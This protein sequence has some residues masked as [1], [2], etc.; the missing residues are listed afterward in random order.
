MQELTAKPRNELGK[1]VNALRRAG[2]LPAVV[3]GEGVK[4]EPLSV[5]LRDF[6]KVYREA[7]ES[8]VIGLKVEG[9]KNKNLNVM[10]HDVAYDALTSK[11]IHADF[12]SVRMDKELEAKVE[13]IFVGESPAVKGE[14][15]ILVKV[16]HEIEVKALPKDLP[17]EIEVDVSFLEAIGSR[18][19]VKDLT[20]PKGVKSIAEG[21]EVVALVEPPRAEEVVVE[22]A[23]TEI[24]EV[25]TEREE[26][27]EVK[28]V[29]E[30]ETKVVETT[31]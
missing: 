6:E 17:H 7:G 2:F 18:I 13:L 8:S 3:Y 27:A 19:Y 10:I 24:A 12:Y 5:S 15:G 26:K 4:S 30:A 11:P 23:T 31:K 9:G 25:K 1:K 28:A 20:F 14:G 21:Q 22:A 29:K 16:M